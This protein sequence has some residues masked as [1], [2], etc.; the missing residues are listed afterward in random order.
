MWSF[1]ATLIITVVAPKIIPAL[2][3][4]LFLTLIFWW[5]INDINTRKKLGFYKMVGVSNFKLVLS[6]YAVDTILTCSF[7]LL[8]QGFI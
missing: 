8:I 1:L 3:T 6:L 7:I 5:L 2:L 4:K